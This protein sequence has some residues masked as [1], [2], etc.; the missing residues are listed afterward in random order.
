MK[1]GNDSFR[2]FLYNHAPILTIISENMSKLE[3][4]NTLLLNGVP[5]LSIL[6]KSHRHRVAIIEGLDKGEIH[7][8][9]TGDKTLVLGTRFHAKPAIDYRDDIRDAFPEEMRSF[10][11]PCSRDGYTT[12][13]CSSTITESLLT[14]ILERHYESDSESKSGSPMSICKP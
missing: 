5:D 10:L 3:L 4:L 2:I 9:E 6:L 11:T 12:L 14:D 13:T 7:W 1:R 8:I